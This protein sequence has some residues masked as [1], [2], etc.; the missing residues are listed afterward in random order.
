MV[1]GGWVNTDTDAE[2]EEEVLTM[3][4]KKEKR[5]GSDR[6]EKMSRLNHMI[7]TIQNLQ[8]TRQ[9]SAVAWWAVELDATLT[10][11]GVEAVK[12][13]AEET[14]GVSNHGKGSPHIQGYRGFMRSVLKKMRDMNWDNAQIELIAKHI[15]DFEEAGAELGHYFVRQCRFRILKNQ[16]RV[17]V[18]YALS[19][20][21]E[22]GLAFQIDTTLHKVWAA[23][24]GT[25]RPG[26]SP[27]SQAEKK[28]QQDIDA[29]KAELGIAKA[30]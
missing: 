26:S 6:E 8:L 22:P 5:G 9:Q 28:L 16:D 20:L 10:K 18:M 1:K 7:C 24:K 21:I 19:S 25:I 29:L 13:H 27:P 4:A 17:L 12:K 3:P 15:T 14:K 2:E 30:K 11:K 23:V